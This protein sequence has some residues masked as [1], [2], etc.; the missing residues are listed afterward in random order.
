MSGTLYGGGGHQD[1]EG[2]P[3]HP[4]TPRYVSR[5]RRKHPGHRSRG[6]EPWKGSGDVGKPRSFSMVQEYTRL[7]DQYPLN[8]F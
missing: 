7:E 8:R 3:T 2:V 5:G 1:E 6:R 4:W